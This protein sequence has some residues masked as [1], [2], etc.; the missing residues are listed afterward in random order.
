MISVTLAASVL[1]E[2]CAS[3][4]ARTDPGPTADAGVDHVVACPGSL[5]TA[6][7]A[8]A[9]V[10][11][12]CTYDCVGDAATA[13]VALCVA[14][15]WQTQPTPC[16]PP[17]PACPTT[18]PVAGE[19][20]TTTTGEACPY[21]RN[22]CCPVAHDTAICIAKK[23]SI[24]LDHCGA[25]TD[26]GTDAPSD[27]LV[28]APPDVSLDAPPDGPV[29]HNGLDGECPLTDPPDAAPCDADLAT[30]WFPHC[31]TPDGAVPT[32][33]TCLD[34]AWNV[35][36]YHCNPPGPTCPDEA[37]LTGVPCALFEGATCSYVRH[38][39][40]PLKFDS[41][42]CLSGA[43]VYTPAVDCVPCP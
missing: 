27:A 30:C 23:W 7:E 4:D 26:G 17:P 36:R 13:G 9:G 11:S 37:P 34:A 25:C 8:C 14:G 43:W 12:A 31:G 42:T 2:A 32:R 40:C 21:D 16:N 38:D 20:C 28:D 41:A 33:A 10:R 24:A 3:D 18:V 5:P 22:E 6:G 35:E 1:P 15:L 39:C 19:A 29:I